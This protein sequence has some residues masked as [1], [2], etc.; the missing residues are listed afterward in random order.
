V[1]GGEIIKAKIDAQSNTEVDFFGDDGAGFSTAPAN[2]SVGTPVR[3]RTAATSSAK[4]DTRR[5]Q[6]GDGTTAS[7]SEVSHT[8]E[9]PGTYQV[10]HTVVAN[11]E[12]FTRSRDVTVGQASEYGIISVTPYINDVEQDDIAVLES[13]DFDLSYRVTVTN[14]SATEDV[15]FQ[16]GGQT[17]TGER[18]GDV[19]VFDVDPTSLDPGAQFTA[20]ATSTTGETATV[21]RPIEVVDLPDWLEGFTGTVLADQSTVEFEATIGVPPGS[22][23]LSLTIPDRFGFADL[24]IPLAGQSQDP[25]SSV[26]AEVS[27]DLATLSTNVTITGSAEYNLTSK[28][29]VSGSLTGSGYFDLEKGELTRATARGDIGT[30]IEFPPPPTGIPSPPVGPVPPGVVRL[31]PIFDIRLGA[32]A[33]FTATD[34][35]GPV[36]LEFQRGSIEPQLTA[37]QELGQKYEIFELVFGLEER[38]AADIPIPSITPVTGSIGAQAYIRAKA[39]GFQ[40]RLALPP[41]D[42][43]LSYQFSIGGGSSAVSPLASGWTETGGTGWQL[44]QPT[45]DTPPKP[46]TLAASGSIS[47]ADVTGSGFITNDSVTDANPSLTQT[48]NGHLTVW[49]R[50]DANKSS[51][52]GRDIYLS[53]RT[54]GAFG[55][56]EPVTNDSTR[57]SEPALAGPTR[58]EQVV[59]FRTLNRTVNASTV[60]SPM[61]LFPHTEIALTRATD[62]GN[63]TEPQLLTNESTDDRHNAP[64]IAHSNGTWLIAWQET[65]ANTTGT[66]GQQVNYLWYNGTTSETTTISGARDPVVAPTG[67]GSLQLAYLDMAEN[68]TTGNVTVSTFD[69]ATQTRQT[70]DRYAVTQFAD[71]ALRNG[72]LAWTDEASPAPVEF[73]PTAGDTS[74]AVPLNL[75]STPQS[76]DLTTS[77]STTLLN[78]RAFT[79]NSSVA[80]VSYAARVDGE[81]L[82]AETYANG[83][84]QNL[85]YWQGASAPARD[86]FVSVFAGKDLGTDQKYDIYTFDQEFRPD[87]SVTATT[88]ADPANTTVGESVTLNY[89]VRNTGVNATA[90]T[91]IALRTNGT[92]TPVENRSGLAPGETLTGTLNTTVDETGTVAVVVDPKSDTDD[93]NR[94]NNSASVRLVTPTLRVSD[95]TVARENGTRTFNITVKNP[96]AAEVP[97]FNYTVEAGPTIQQQGTIASLEPGA[98]A[99][100]SLTAPIADIDPQYALRLR[101]SPSVSDASSQSMVRFSTPLRP[102]LSLDSGELGYYRSGNTTTAV[103]AVGNAGLTETEAVVTVTNQTSSGTLATERRRI[104]ASDGLNDTAFTEVIVP[105][106]DVSGNQTLR[107]EVSRTAMTERVAATAVDEVALGTALL[108][109]RAEIQLNRTTASVDW[110]IEL[111]AANVSSPVG[112]VTQ[113][114][115]QVNGTQTNESDVVFTPQETGTQNVSL[116]VVN[117]Q[118]LPRLVEQTIQVVGLPVNDPPRDVDGDGQ[119]EDVSGTRGFSIL[120]I[121]ALFNNLDD[122]VIQKN[123]D[124]FKFADTGGEVSVLDVQALFNEL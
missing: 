34:G 97:R 7:G 53:Q 41:G 117:D 13:V 44:Q 116:V 98:N 95:V 12:E 50:Q 62:D 67:D 112:N 59:V 123:A 11:G 9:E 3:F 75:S 83:S 115:W 48:E 32:D 120:D 56:I 26:T 96:L 43:R 15:T 73:V 66:A 72:S 100:I 35:S 105:L 74:T 90:T 94:R 80:Q 65:V 60:S 102:Q 5:W 113:F 61:E 31:F 4:I 20:T 103:L 63:W 79:G 25:K 19:W 30:T 81:W 18:T 47:T 16:I 55:G 58:T 93:R 6:F 119:Y 118:G 45:G 2:P 91:P 39:F 40:Q 36:P 107:F 77:N 104:N 124:A 110:A 29:A 111:R 54:G 87:L 86:G 76:I 121:Q 33:Q 8:Y 14:P 82:P 89:T 27:I 57:D 64:T 92:V 109:P 108:P 106:G 78:A 71:I 42:E 101:A 23:S 49:S 88:P 51:L 114:Q 17:Y 21:S 28:L 10:E 85:T 84:A 38:L 52:N 22:S 68:R 99:T 24:D 1:N 122:P 69:P 70:T 46:S 37:R